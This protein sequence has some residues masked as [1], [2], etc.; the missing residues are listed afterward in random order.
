MTKYVLRVSRKENAAPA[1]QVY[2]KE[3]EFLSVAIAELWS[4]VQLLER[5]RNCTREVADETGKFE[6]SVLIR[7]TRGHTEVAYLLT[8][9]IEGD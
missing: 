7:Y 4:H 2:K 1:V 6:Q 9:T 3:C 5:V 8:I